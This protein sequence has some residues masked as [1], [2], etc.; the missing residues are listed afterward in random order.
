[1]R[2]FYRILLQS[3]EKCSYEYDQKRIFRKNSVQVSSKAELYVDFRFAKIQQNH[4]R[5]KS[6]FQ[7]SDGQAEFLIF[8]TN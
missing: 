4:S 8:I 1:L 3:A 5:Q 7:I 6:N 2:Y